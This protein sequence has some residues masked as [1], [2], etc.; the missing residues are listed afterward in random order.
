MRIFLKHIQK[1]VSAWPSSGFPKAIFGV[2]GIALFSVSCAKESVPPDLLRL[3]VAQGPEALDTRFTSSAVAQRLG[4][5]VYAPLFLIG[6]DLAAAP[7]LAKTLIAVDATHTEVELRDD[8]FFSD[9]S[10]LTAKD[11]VYT[12]KSLSDDEVGSIHKARFKWLL[13]VEEIGPHRVRFTLEKPFAAFPMELCAI[14]IVQKRSCAQ[15]TPRCRRERVASGPFQVVNFD[16]E[17]E[18]LL[19]KKN[20]FFFAKN[21]WPRQGVQELLVRVVQDDTTRL[22]ELLD[23]KA[24]LLVGDIGP[25]QLD[26]IAGKR[27]K[28]KG[29]RV[30]RKGGL[31][32]S[33]LAMNL[34]GP[35]TKGE[36]E[37]ENEESPERKRTLE[38][39]ANPKVRLAIAHALDVDRIIKT[40]LRDSAKRA[41]GMLPPSHWAKNPWLKVPNF[42]PERARLLLD[43]AGFA[44]RGEDAG[45]RFKI[46][47]N[48]TT[49]RLRRSIALI[50]AHQMREVGIDVTVRVGEWSTLYADIKRGNFEMFSAKWTPVV[51][52][53]LFHW[54]F[55]SSSIPSAKGAGGNRGAYV[56]AA[57]DKLIEEGRAT[58]EQSARAAAYAQVEG[59]LLRDLPYVPLWFEDQ[60]SLT[61]N[62][63]QSYAPMRSGALNSIADV[64]LSSNMS[65]RKE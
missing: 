19:L 25:T 23:G 17:S 20:E 5:L 59:Y 54:V 28:E 10:P 16:V 14:G 50:F 61:S 49:N 58:Q 18:E 7:Y 8:A 37:N 38:A 43:E 34:R 2:L 64:V 11:V 48:T 57:V 47:L 15:N 44:D 55:H 4:F 27:G 36:N 40:K 31:G 56:N 9:G 26:V 41:S 22:L 12:Y 53:D 30:H 3:V 63:I 65:G 21:K 62:R 45:R 52:P 46:T 29:V 39:L 42:D 1:S 6:D 35:S 13:D 51:E 32:Y 33:Y 60:I 24:D